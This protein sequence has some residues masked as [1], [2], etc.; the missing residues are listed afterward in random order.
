ML[1]KLLVLCSMLIAVLFTG[2][3]EKKELEVASKEK[4]DTLVY[5]QL[6]EGKTLDPQDSTEQYSQVVTTQIYDRLVEIDEMTGKLVPGLAD[7]WER[8]DDL[9]L[10]MHLNKKAKFHNGDL[11]KASD[12]KFTLE[13]AK[14]KPKVAHLYKAIKDIEIIDDN[15]IKIITEEPFAPLLNHLSHKTAAIISEKYFKQNGDN[16]FMKPIGTGSYKFKNW[17]VG[18]N[19]TLEANDEYFKGKPSIKTII[20]KG[21]PEENSR[22]I[23]L[24]TGE[25]DIAEG[26]ATIGRKAIEDSKDLTL[27]EYPSTSVTYL[28]FSLKNPIL[29]DKDVRRAIAMGINR[30]EIVKGLM[31]GDVKIANGF[32]AP[33]VFGYSKDSKVL[34]YNKEE[35]K[36]IIESKG[37]KGAKLSL[38]TSNNQLRAQMAEIM[39]AQ[40]KEIG[41]DVTLQTLEWG[42]FL[43]STGNGE[44]D[45]FM[46]GWGPSTY[47]GDYGLYPNFHSSQFGGNGNRTFYSNQKVDELLDNAKKEMDIE[48]RR[49]MYIEIINIVNEDVPVL[50]INYSNTIIGVT[51][52]LEGV[53]PISYPM[54]YKYNFKK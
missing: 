26:I 1:K 49:N 7:S 3:G 35:A 52:K 38:V 24:E 18:E 5:A 17:V 10:I 23:G 32:L 12:V 33:S 40:L 6:S 54:F 29:Q 30:E 4:K 14:S 28:G 19:I 22:V 42:A 34:S 13:R 11:L 8:V 39:Q 2:C 44:L 31:F 21:I 27:M 51:N 36:G 15:T 37:L 20:I 25:I 9:T 48:K 41:L 43:K 16:Y 45:M 47:D 46:M 50:P 53:Q